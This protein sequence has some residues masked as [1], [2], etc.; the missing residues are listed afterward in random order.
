MQAESYELDECAVALYLEVPGSK[1]VM[2]QAF[3][4][5]YEAIGVVRTIDI[6]RSRVCVV[7][8]R[9]ML[10]DCMRLLEALREYVDWS[11]VEPPD[12]YEKIFGYFK[13]RRNRD[14]K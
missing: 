5:M 1:V 8:T 9:D 7:T 6:R 10:P 13:D 2:F 14:D 4:D 3:F 12:D 11:F